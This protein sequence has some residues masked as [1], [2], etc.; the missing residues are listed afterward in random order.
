MKGANLKKQMDNNYFRVKGV[1]ATKPEKLIDEDN[2]LYLAMTIKVRGGDSYIQLPLVFYGTKVDAISTV[3]HLG[4]KAMFEGLFVNILGQ[5][6][7]LVARHTLL[8]TSKVDT[9]EIDRFREIIK[10]YSLVELLE[11]DKK[12]DGDS[13]TQ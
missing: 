2:A 8:E 6:T 11:R 9:S 1:V 5:P 3:Y 12:E 7:M 13:T 4:D 10:K